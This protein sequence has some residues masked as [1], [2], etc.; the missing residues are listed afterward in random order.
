MV[1]TGPAATATTTDCPV[2]ARVRPQNLMDRTQRAL[3]DAQQRTLEYIGCRIAFVECRPGFVD[4]RPPLREPAR[5]APARPRVVSRLSS[6]S[7]TPVSPS[8]PSPSSPQALYYL[9]MEFPQRLSACALQSLP[10]LLSAALAQVDPAAEG[11]C[12]AAALEGCVRGW[13]RAALDGGPGRAF[14]VED[15]ALLEEDLELLASFFRRQR[16]LGEEVIRNVLAKPRALLNAFGLDTPTLI[17]LH[18][19]ALAG[20]PCALPEGDL[21]RVLCHRAVRAGAQA[22]PSFPRALTGRRNARLGSSP[23]CC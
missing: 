14:A 21:L 16:G 12:A 4:V 20:R 17:A 6:L 13:R 2:S 1:P 15:H 8:L 23:A 7:L 3:A 18:E 22:S 10:A 11:A 19:D 9:G 5:P